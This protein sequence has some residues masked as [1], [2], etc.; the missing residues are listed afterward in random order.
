MWS[1]NGRRMRPLPMDP[2]VGFLHR[3]RPGRAGLALDLM[4]ELRPVLADRVALS[5]L[6]RGQ[7]TARDFERHE[8]GAVLLR[9]DARKTVLTSYQ[10]RKREELVHPFLE[11]K[12][13]I[14]LIGEIDPAVDSLRF[15]H[16]GANA[17]RRIEHIGAKPAQDF[18]APLIF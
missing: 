4:E 9:D 13:T 3:D 12:V 5:L 14:G 8:G 16:L 15:Y 11:E 18:D 1:G 7:V 2:Q 6:N 17:A 10:E